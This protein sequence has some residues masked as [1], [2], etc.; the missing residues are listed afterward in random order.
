M[1]NGRLIGLHDGP[2]PGGKLFGAAVI[3]YR[4]PADGL[5]YILVS[6]HQ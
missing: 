4:N 3:R 2:T 6:Y 5:R 1:G